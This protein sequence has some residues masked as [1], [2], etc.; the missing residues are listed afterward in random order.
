VDGALRTFDA[1]MSSGQLLLWCLLAGLLGPVAT[2][3]HE[4]GHAAVGL[5]RSDGI[6]GV[7][8]GRHP[9]IWRGRVGRLVFSFHPFPSSAEKIAGGAVTAARLSAR[10]RAL[11]ALAGPAAQLLFA[12]VVAALGAPVVAVLIAAGALASLVPRRVGK[13]ATDGW[14]FLQAV[15][16]RPTGHSDQQ[17]TSARAR[18]LFER[19]DLHLQARNA[20]LGAAAN[21][22]ATL[23]RAAFAGWCW[24]HAQRADLGDTR[25]AALDALHEATITGVVEPQLT[26]DAARRLAASLADFGDLFVAGMASAVAG[27]AQITAFRYGGALHDVELI[28]G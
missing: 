23:L 25:E 9:G 19:P 1:F 16:G 3:V 26:I 2:A 4:L 7:R 27:E 20:T 24:R 6:V 21:G 10:D 15:R 17:D 18:L 14:H 11:Y 8:V 5:S 28:R 22:D 13:Y 12:A